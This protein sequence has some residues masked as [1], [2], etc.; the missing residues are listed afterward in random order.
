MLLVF[1]INTK[2][3]TM[4]WKQASMMKTTTFS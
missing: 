4:I 2:M 3:K 1:F